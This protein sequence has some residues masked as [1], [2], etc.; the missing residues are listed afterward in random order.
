M[1]CHCMFCV[2]NLIV[3]VNSLIVSDDVYVRNNDNVIEINNETDR[4]R[5]LFV[6]VLGRAVYCVVNIR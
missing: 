3:L 4:D 2:V 6:I 5:G 1:I